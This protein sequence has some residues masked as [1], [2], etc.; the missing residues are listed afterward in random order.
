LDPW[1]QRSR[2]LVL[3]ER[4]FRRIELTWTANLR[5]SEYIGLTKRHLPRANRCLRI[6]RDQ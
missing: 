3:G 4:V 6:A 2:K 5:T 1:P